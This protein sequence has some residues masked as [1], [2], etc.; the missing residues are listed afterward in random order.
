MVKKE[1]FYFL[2]IVSVSTVISFEL[3]VCCP[4]DLF[5]TEHTRTCVCYIL[6]HK[7]RSEG[8]MQDGQCCDRFCT[9]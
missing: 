4:W 7:K 6:F 9:D 2:F 8:P 1:H 5:C 3:H